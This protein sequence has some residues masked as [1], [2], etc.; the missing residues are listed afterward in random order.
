MY[1][2]RES[3]LQ[4]VRI[5]PRVLQPP[6][7]RYAQRP[8]MARRVRKAV[9]SVLTFPGNGSVS[10]TVTRQS[11]STAARAV[12]CGP[13]DRNLH[14]GRFQRHCPAASAGPAV[15]LTTTWVSPRFALAVRVRSGPGVGIGVVI[16]RTSAQEVASLT[17]LEEKNTLFLGPDVDTTGVPF[18][19]ETIGG[20]ERVANMPAVGTSS[21]ASTPSLR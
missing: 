7:R 2:L 12:D 4:G 16:G 20:I 14:Q 21:S 17:F 6:R 3:I 18:F 13:G 9:E 11:G 8:Y 19:D 1:S 15:M 10:V 5:H